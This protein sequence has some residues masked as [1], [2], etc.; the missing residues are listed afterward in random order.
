MVTLDQ[1][2]DLAL[3]LPEAVEGERHGHRTWFVAGKAFAWHRT[4]SKADLRR[5]GDERPPHGPIV[6]MRVA[7]LHEKEAVL[8]SGSA[9]LFSIP[10]FDSYPAVLV[11][12]QAVSKRLLREL[13][14][15]AWLACAP[16][17]IATAHLADLEVQRRRG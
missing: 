9:G 17:D 6:A 1:V 7:D 15:D 14:T 5:Y 11:Q 12:L 8:A 4:F 2:A 16:R 13:M 10:H 3:S